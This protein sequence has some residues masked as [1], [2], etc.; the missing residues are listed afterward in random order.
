MDSFNPKL[1]DM[2]ESLNWKL[3]RFSKIS[4][5]GV[6]SFICAPGISKKSAESTA[7]QECLYFENPE[8]PTDRSLLLEIKEMRDN[9]WVFPMGNNEE[10][11]FS[12][13]PDKLAQILLGR[14]TNGNFW[15][16]STNN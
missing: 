1:I 9:N 8:Y 10:G 15:V 7:G 13:D 14:F 4:M 3:P 16:S 6:I 11:S 2:L 12:G 5:N